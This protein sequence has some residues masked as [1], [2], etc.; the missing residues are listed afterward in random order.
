[1]TSKLA[2]AADETDGAIINAQMSDLMVMIKYTSLS[3]ILSTNAVFDVA[4][5][6]HDSTRKTRNH[7]G[8]VAPPNRV[9]QDHAE[10]L[11]L[12]RRRDRARPAEAERTFTEHWNNA[13][14]PARGD[15]ADAG[16]AATGA[17]AA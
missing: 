4:I 8:R 11:H 9:G 14:A 3:D 13:A 6:G 7:L 17:I 5:G 2:T 12:R 15:T 10:R 1:M 16:K